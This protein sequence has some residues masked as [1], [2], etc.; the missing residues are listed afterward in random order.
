[1]DRNERSRILIVEDDDDLR[2]ALEML[3]VDD[4]FD[5]ESAEHGGIALKILEDIQP[6]AILLDLNMPVMDG[7]TFAR[8]YRSRHGRQVPILIYSATPPPRIA[9]DIENTRILRKPL[10]TDDLLTAIRDTAV[11]GQ[12][13]G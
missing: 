7:E 4:G 6:D 3:L 13:F 2:I 10:E 8:E 5:V 11:N 12:L 1:M 9:D